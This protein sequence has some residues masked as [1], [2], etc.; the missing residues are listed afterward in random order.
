MSKISELGPSTGANTRTE[1]LFVIVNLV[2]GDDGT[3]NITRKELVEAIQ[4][5]IF[6]RI[7]I[8]G[9][10]IA[11]VVMS[12]STLNTVIINSSDFNLGE[13]DR[14]SFDRGTINDSVITDSSANNLVI[15]NS[16]FST[17]GISTSTFDDGTITDSTGDNLT[18]TNSSFAT[19]NISESSISTSDFDLGT[20]TNSTANNLVITNSEINDG[21]GN[22]M[23]FTN[24]TIDDSTYNN[25]TIDQGTANGLILTNIEID[26]LLLED[27]EISNSSITTT[28]FEDGTISNTAIDTSTFVSGRILNSTANTLSIDDGSFY[29]ST[30][31]NIDLQ[32]SVFNNGTISNS[33]LANNVI[34]NSSFQGTMDDVV[35]Q[36]MT[37]TSST[38]AN[39]GLTQ[40]TFQG[41]IVDS[42]ISN[43]SIEDLDLD[44]VVIRNSKILESE[45]TNFDMNL[46][47]QWEPKMDEDSYFAIK[48]AKTGDTEKI[49]YRQLFDEVSKNTEK[50]LKIHVAVDGDDSKPG[51]ILQPVK[52]LERAA[53]LALEKA[54]GSFNRNG[55]NDPVHISVGPG[56]HYTK[57]NV[58]LPDDCAI[59]ST[60]GQYATVIQALPGYEMNNAILLGS[61]G[62]SQGFSFFN[63][64][65]DNFDYPSGG[66]AY[67]YRPGAKILRSPYVRDSSQLSNF[68]RLDVEP[69][70][71]PFNTKG[72][73][74]DLGRQLIMEAGHSGAFTEG[75]EVTFSSGAFGI[76]SWDDDVASSDEVYVRNLKGNVE[77]GDYIYAQSG[78]VGQIKTVG[79]D[80]FPNPLV[81]R[82][83]GVVLADR[84]QLDPDSLYTYWLCFGA[85]PRT[86]NGIGYVAKNGAGVNGIGSLSI[87]VRVAFYALD[88][89]QMTLNNSGTQFGDISMRS[90]GSTQVFQPTLTEAQLVQNTVF[91][92]AILDNAGLIIEDMVDYLTANTANGGLNYQAYDS[93]KC[94]RDTGII[95]DSVGYDV[96]LN[97]NYWGRLNGITYRSPIS[98]RVYGE[99]LNET[100]GAIR[101]LKGEVE[102]I[103]RNSQVAVVERANT[104][105]NETLNILEYGEDYA[106][107]LT[108]SDTG[109]SAQVGA[110]QQIQENR[111]FIQDALLDWI[112]NNE[113]FYAYD[114]GKCRR[115]IEDYIL[116]AVKYDML[117]ETN[118]NAVTAGN[119]YYMGTA[120]KVIGQQRNET[121]GSF[122]YL[123]KITDDVLQANSSSAAVATYESFNEIINIL[124]NAGKK[125]TP[126][127]A[128]YNPTT[129]SMTVNIGLHDLQVG[130]KILIDPESMVFTCSD[131]NYVTE[132]SHPRPSDRVAYQRPLPI[133]ARTVTTITF[134]VGKAGVP[135][136]HKFMRSTKDCITLLGSNIVYSDNAAL[137]TDHKNARKQLQTNRTYIQDYMMAWIDDNYYIY[138]SDKCRRDTSQY[139]LPA[140]QRD[141]LLGTN[142]NS[143]QTGVAYYT[144]T[145][146]EVLK[147]QLDQTAG[148]IT[149]LK[150][151][152]N[153]ETLSDISAYEKTNEAFDKIIG[154]MLNA[155]KTYTPTNAA[156]D[157][158]TGLMEITLGDH[159]IQVGHAIVF[160]DLSIT[161]SC[162]D[163]LGNP[164]EITHP[165]KTDPAYRTAMKVLEVTGTTVTINTGPAGVDKVHTFVSAAADSIRVSTYTGKYTPQSATYNGATGEFVATIGQHNI[166]V[167]QYIEIAPNS[168]VFTCSLDNNITEHPTPAPHHPAY[169]TP[170]V[171]SAVT[172]NSI[173]VN[174][175][176]GAGG[177]HTFVRADV[178]A[179]NADALIWSD[180]AKYNSYVT[181]T[182]ATY[183]P[184]TGVSEITIG[185]HTLTTGDFV[186][187]MPYSLTFTCSQDSNATEHSYPRR[188]DGN[189]RVPVEITGTTSTTITVNVGAGAGGTHT[190]VRAAADAIA[191]TNTSANSTNAR[192][193]I[194]DNKEFIKG[195]VV[196]YLNDNYFTY[197]G[198]RCARDT[199]LILDAV[200]RDVLTGSNFSS[201]FAG[202]AYRAGTASGDIVVTDQLTETV[203]AITWLKGEIGSNISG[204]SLTR[205][206]AAFD[207]IIDIMNNG[208]G[209]A[210]AISFG[211]ETVGST[212]TDARIALQNNKVFLQAEIN[213]WIAVNYPDHTYDTAKC[214]RDLGFIIDSVSFDIQHGSNTGSVNNARLYF[215]KAVS[216]LPESQQLITAEAFEHI[217][218]LA[219]KLVRGE[220]VTASVGNFQSTDTSVPAG[221]TPTDA[222]YNH[223]SGYMTLTFGSAHGLSV[224]DRVNF[225]ENSITFSCPDDLGSP[226]NIS[227]PRSTDPIFGDSVEIT[228][229]TANTITMYVYPAKVDKVHTFVSATTG[230]VKPT[231]SGPS[232]RTAQLFNIIS[233]MIRG[234]DFSELPAYDEPTVT[235]AAEY[236]SAAEYIAG[237]TGKYQVEILDFINSEYN[238]LAYDEV[239]CRRDIGY[240]LDAI[241][242]DIEYGGNEATI[243]AANYYF[244]R[245]QQLIEE[246]P[247]K[248]TLPTGSNTTNLSLAA[249]DGPVPNYSDYIT[250]V[251][252]LPKLQ[253]EPTRL[254]YVH[255]ADVLEDVVQK[256]QVTPSF[257]A[258]FTPT[259]ATYDPA[260]GVFVATIGTHSLVAGD[261]IW[262][263]DDGITF[264]CDMGA[265]GG[266]QNHTSPQAH[267]PFYRRPVKITSVVANTS[268]TMNVGTGGSGQQPHTFVSAVPNAIS[269]ITGAVNV[270]GQ[271]FRGTASDAATA[272]VG[273]NLILDIANAID[274]FS[275]PADI[276]AISGAPTSNPKRTYAREQIQLNRDFIIDEVVSYINDQYYTYDEAKCARDAGFILDA[277]ARDIL[278]G[279]NYNSIYSG[280]AYRIGTAGANKTINEQLAETIEGFKYVQRKVEASLTGNALARATAGFTELYDVMTNGET[281]A[282]GYVFGTA[283]ISTSNGNATA[284]L[285]ANREF[286]KEEIV[287]YINQNFGSLV[288]DQNKCKRDTGHFVDALSYD[289]QHGS[290][291]GVR[292]FA[293][294]YFENAISVLPADQQPATVSAWTRLGVVAE[295]IVLKQPVTASPG[296]VVI[297]DTSSFGGTTAPIAQQIQDLTKIVSDAIDAN[298]ISQL[299]AE[300]LPQTENSNATGYDLEYTE[301]YTT[302][303]ALKSVIQRDIVAYL[304]SK[305]NYLEYDESKCRRDTGYIVD[306]ISHDIQYGGNAATVNAAGIYFENA[307]NVL[308]RDQREPTKRAFEH[309]GEIVEHIIYNNTITPSRGNNQSQTTANVPGANPAKPEIATDAKNLAWIISA[310]ADDENPANIPA[311]KDPDMSWVGSNYT[312]AKELLD[313]NTNELAESV[314]KYISTTYKGLSFP[315]NQCRRD[316]G[317]LIDAVSHDI[318]YSTN[319]A[320]RQSAQIYFEN[321]I[322]VLP[323]D[324][325]EQ[326]A[327]VYEKM[328][329]LIS[330]VVQEIDTSNVSFSIA[331]TQDISGIPANANTAVQVSELIE[332]IEQVIRND[333]TAVIPPLDEPD[334]SWVSAD[335]V[336]AA[337]AI[338]ENSDTFADDVQIWLKENFTVLDYNKAKCR[339]DTGYLIDAFSFDLNYGGNAASRWNADFY[340]WNNIYRIPEDQRVPTALSYRQLGKICSDVILGKAVGQVLEGE[341]GTEVEADKVKKLANIFYNTQYNDST[342]YLPVLEYPNFNWETNKIFNFSR[343]ILISRRRELQSEVVRHVNQEYGFL[344]I[345]LARRDAM[346]LLVAFTNDF[347]FINTSQAV[348]GSYFGDGYGSQKSLGAFVASFF[349]FDGTHVFPVFNP[350]SN[351]KDLS[352]KGAVIDINNVIT[353]DI[354]QNDAYIQST[355][356]NGNRFAGTIYA[357]DLSLNAG[358]GGWANIGA[359][360]VDLLYSFYK[361]FERMRD[362][363]NTNLTPADS[364]SYHQ[365]MVNGLFNDVLIGNLLRPNVLTFGS[366]VESIAHQ[367]NG[368]SAGVNRTA[369]PL[370]FRNLGSA[371]SA[372]A[373]V[374]SEDGGRIRWSG[375]DELNNQYFARGLRINGQTGRIEGRPFT[376]SVRKLAR[377]ASNSRAIV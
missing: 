252:S 87:F 307:V 172:P 195:E 218:E 183:I 8:T 245:G 360:N 224:G 59:T 230:G 192:K 254:A 290:N 180:P 25:V 63:W 179:I 16:T 90:K 362:Y 22:N 156:Y 240:I 361:S 352:F 181:P 223:T 285:Q 315:E 160:D 329:S 229:V 161:F 86:Q 289:I 12:N 125:F 190:F 150:G 359:N 145:A 220:D 354:K 219:R 164:V 126:V 243:T 318:N 146:S 93:D 316:I 277:V 294:L 196:A 335:K 112:D 358:A 53:E 291:T 321:G 322:S 211:T 43:T 337:S 108:F 275:K 135:F 350:P 333:S 348:A 105:F 139:I 52:T 266:V 111:S 373:S 14:S 279:S 174:V 295:Q 144:A 268:I 244:I 259:N 136:A 34:S 370:N 248:Q 140:V 270:V 115:D 272:L 213:A 251:N 95:I 201:V 186:E 202:L 68:N 308:D 357:W 153:S 364:N 208:Q 232:L 249:Y 66:F 28:S 300:V 222:D 137:D 138:D 178:G 273:K 127:T 60:S 265:G 13:I 287:A 234:D 363:I 81:G 46:A 205:S 225:D 209:N 42:T 226:V 299:P 15:T 176:P 257:G 70:L 84:K 20:V 3:K 198:V 114:S 281:A 336:W 214:E 41:A 26:E 184:A 303:V 91:A 247:E 242:Q 296:N 147:D 92:D 167:G 106:N 113:E 264:S 317:I 24:S 57:G 283:S 343:D 367:F 355:D 130:Q 120:R 85:T 346:N 170:I 324:T 50:A 103:F 132:I 191:I 102:H 255:M 241:A 326:T 158:I 313:T 325:R 288:Y 286:M 32:T 17:G 109:N 10:T 40:S 64:Q 88:G 250:L 207:E 228:E 71:S 342:Q 48:N 37:I 157:H 23:V 78:G 353:D 233:D 331:S 344:D 194:M 124:D 30:G 310:I 76:I 165:R 73:V 302:A 351:Y 328:S 319:Q 293:R 263:A 189:Y 168:V 99:Q 262:L 56:T 96:A 365:G 256:T 141:M 104:S 197:D 339:R 203:G 372:L 69:P 119:A 276:P 143:V 4:Y 149:Y 6:S 175:G 199:G 261:Y 188:G 79:I 75:D 185:T 216:V 340:Y 284:G 366:L 1:D 239:K 33:V 301:G 117:L 237:A 29:N 309:L 253:R 82:G 267:H 31:E 54:G 94:K 107:P 55:L 45:L 371:I 142:F 133:T 368:A 260:T 72:T 238:G 377:R 44:N 9:G 177:T 67:A 171:V 74:A 227:H 155:G 65:V 231:A 349:D 98:Q 62:Y 320:I 110:R 271:E 258:Q 375:S 131:D 212:Y 173:T 280:L 210:D 49:S 129:G 338:D 134:L 236:S 246:Y 151:Q 18:I 35:A 97:T 305:F 122:E 5:E 187:I 204:T 27:A 101:H 159:D 7:T 128:D 297:Q 278:T 282:D 206:N 345:N 304:N 100:A 47:D 80:D 356:Y 374:L 83:G 89:G 200:R 330:D 21:T 312:A 121:V 154:I 11:N 166:Q 298:T 116:P 58:A 182:T 61:G 306:A 269:E 36:N 148:A 215:N 51:T 327:D 292:N 376:S 162:P 19:G 332:V 169:K 274:D 311:R 163:D 77:V 334:T 217:A 347:R 38:A 193:Q 235:V 123:R 323:I 369:L 341:K 39:T 2:Q 314:I 152:V 118:Y 221:L